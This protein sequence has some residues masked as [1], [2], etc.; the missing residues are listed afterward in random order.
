MIGMFIHFRRLKMS[1]LSKALLGCAAGALAACSSTTAT[2]I[3]TPGSAAAAAGGNYTLTQDGVTR[4]LPAPSGT[5]GLGLNYWNLASVKGYKYENADVVAIAV[6][7][8]TTNDTFTGISG[9]A[10]ASVPTSGSA[11]YTGD[12]SATYYRGG[13]INL[14]WSASGGFSTLVNFGS[15]AVTGSGS[16]S[17]STNLSL[18]GTVSG[19]S[20]TGTATFS[21]VD[22]TGEAT[23]PMAGGFYGAGTIAGVY[24]GNR[25]T[26]VFWGQ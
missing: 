12:F 8:R 21:G 3:L 9:T 18:D 6:M 17:Y 10:A 11:L 13:T 16:G 1:L 2:P 20:I 7:D 15:G 19:T 14:P 24:Q 5:A 23:V 25:L 4:T 26:G 22:Y